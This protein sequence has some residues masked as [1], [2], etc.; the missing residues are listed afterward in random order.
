MNALE[1]AASHPNAY[2]GGLFWVT[3]SGSTVYSRVEALLAHAQS[4]GIQA[5]LIETETFDEL[6]GDLAQQVDDLPPD[7]LGTLNK[8]R[9]KV[10]NVALPAPGTGWPV[11][12]MNAVPILSWPKECR[13]FDAQIGGA[14][15]LRELLQATSADLVAVRSQYGVLAFGTDAEVRRVF[16]AHQPENLDLH[17]IEAGRLWRETN[18][19]NLLR[20]ALVHGLLIRP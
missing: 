9:S 16:A 1:E 5:A 2:P 4:A 10:S 17:S 18:E 3:R 12:R 11:V 19:L 8:M 6:M 15:E 7:L 13:K 14:K 20:N